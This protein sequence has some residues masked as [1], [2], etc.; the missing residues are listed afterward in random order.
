MQLVTL[1]KQFL[2]NVIINQHRIYNFLCKLDSKQADTHPL[3]QWKRF[4]Q[5]VGLHIVSQ[6]QAGRATG[7]QPIINNTNFLLWL[8]LYFSSPATVHINIMHRKHV[9]YLIVTTDHQ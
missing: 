3:V 1:V 2:I 5:M 9:L 8:K 6:L 7:S 4:T